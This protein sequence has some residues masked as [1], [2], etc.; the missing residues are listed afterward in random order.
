MGIGLGK[1]PQSKDVK[2][3][4]GLLDSFDLSLDSNG[5]SKTDIGLSFES[6]SD[7]EKEQLKQAQELIN[8]ANTRKTSFKQTLDL[9]NKGLLGMIGKAL[10]IEEQ[11]SSIE[12]DISRDKESQ[13]DNEDIRMDL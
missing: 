9:N 6:M 4:M 2:E 13:R 8:D 7:K 1:E 11:Q 10:G 3:K 5:N 12:Q